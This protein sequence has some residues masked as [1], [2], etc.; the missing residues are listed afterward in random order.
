MMNS[1]S[2]V[3]M[4]AAVRDRA[5]RGSSEWH[6]AQSHAIM[7]TPCEVPVPRKVISSPAATF[8]PSGKLS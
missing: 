3:R 6:T 1:I 4:R 2:G 8:I 7:G 5:S